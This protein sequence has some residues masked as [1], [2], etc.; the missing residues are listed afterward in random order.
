[1]LRDDIGRRYWRHVQGEERR[2]YF[3]LAAL[4]PAASTFASVGAAASLLGGGIAA[5]GAIQSSEAQSASLK[6]QAQVAANNAIIANQNAAQTTQSGEALSSAQ[7]M[8][9]RQNAGAIVAAQ[10]ASGVDLSSPS[11]VDVRSSA[12]QL[13]ELDALTIRSNTARQAY[14]YETQASSDI[15]Q[16]GAD[17]AGAQNAQ[18]AGGINATASLL[19]GVSGAASKYAQ[20]SQTGGSTA[21]SGQIVG[22]S[23]QTQSWGDNSTPAE[24]QWS[25]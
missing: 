8:K 13:G 7:A 9:T 15:G 22:Q 3:A 12:A 18:V 14:G 21:P 20:W 5:Y 25:F 11:S 10:S 19:S 24:A 4:I 23:Q 1:M 2:R 16:Q 6:Y 17:V